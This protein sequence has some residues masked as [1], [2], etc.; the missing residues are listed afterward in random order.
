[1]QI[2]SCMIFMAMTMHFDRHSRCSRH[3]EIDFVKI[4]WLDLAR[5]W[6]ACTCGHA[7]LSRPAQYAYPAYCETASIASMDNISSI[8][9]DIKVI[10]EHFYIVYM[11]IYLI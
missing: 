11:H 7:G 10:S 9:I 1:M 8:Q 4:H 5:P 3:T 2:G 6:L